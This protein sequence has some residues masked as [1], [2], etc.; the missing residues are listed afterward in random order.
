MS[1]SMYNTCICVYMHTTRTHTCIFDPRMYVYTGA[2][3]ASWPD[4]TTTAP[5][6]CGRR[7]RP[8]LAALWLGLC[9]L[10]HGL[11]RRSGIYD[12]PMHTCIYAHAV[13][14]TRVR[15]ARW[16]CCWVSSSRHG[17]QNG[18]TCR[19]TCSQPCRCV[20]SEGYVYIFT[21]IYVDMCVYV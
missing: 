15:V 18:W 11:V 1:I 12:L 8:A 21:C 17:G 7:P 20:R 2:A 5:I 9:S 16:K 3:G 4:T 6:F 13:M 10:C 19:Q 14:L